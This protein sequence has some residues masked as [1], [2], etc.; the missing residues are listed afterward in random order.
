MSRFL[1]SAIV[2]VSLV[3]AAG[4]ASSPGAA[5]DATPATSAG[6]PVS[7]QSEDLLSATFERTASGPIEL[8][9]L[10]ILLDSG[11]SSPLHAHP[12]LEL[13]VVESG[14]LMT[15][16]AGRALM[17]RGSDGEPEPAPEGVEVRLTAGDRIAY[18]PGTQMTFRNPGPEETVLLAATVLPA[19]PDAPPGAVY[20][21]G[22]PTAEETAGVQSQLLGAAEILDFPPGR[23]A[24]VL[25]RLQ[26][27]AGES[28]PAFA[29]PLL[30]AVESGA[31]S[32]SVLEGSIETTSATSAAAEADDEMFSLGPG[33]SVV[34]PQGIAES[35]PLG[36]TGSV[37]LLRLG[38]LPL[39][40]EGPPTATAVATTPPTTATDPTGNLVIVVVAE[41]RLRGEPSLDGS[42][43]A[44]LP[45]GSVL[46]VTGPPVEGSGVIWHPVSAA[47]NPALTGYVAADLIAPAG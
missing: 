24:V 19:G 32:G 45:Q 29:G 23:A 4:V 1:H 18:A 44:G 34:L 43:V 28:L 3:C 8:R 13:G 36:G 6:A 41:A 31:L 14:T 5:Q 35:P 21:A 30:V 20:A 9:L 37:V 25:D 22:T 27:R 46:V 17:Q 26:L 7:P 40:D 15:R 16:V 47:D 42:L 12:G 2:L 39:V 33:Q 11:G 10:R 38:A